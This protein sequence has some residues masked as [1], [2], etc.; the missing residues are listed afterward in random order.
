MA[1]R[2]SV[3]VREVPREMTTPHAESFFEQ[4]KPLLRSHRPQLVFDFSPVAVIDTV[5][6]G[7]LLRCLA[8]AMQRNGDIKL[9]VVKPM[10]LEVLELT[11][12]ASL[13]ETFPSP[14]EAVASFHSMLPVGSSPELMQIDAALQKD[15][16][17][18]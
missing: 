9:A 1:N 4:L 18:V 14:E 5:G 10:A 7:V 2:K 11:H 3:T 6:V 8:Q 17:V 13:F 16:V 12:A 15:E